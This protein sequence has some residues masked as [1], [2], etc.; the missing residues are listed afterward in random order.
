[1][2]RVRYKPNLR[3]NYSTKQT[4]EWSC[5]NRL[6]KIS[7][8]NMWISQDAPHEVR[9][10]FIWK[11]SW[12][13]KFS[14]RSCS[15]NQPK[16]PY[17]CIFIGGLEYLMTFKAKVPSALG[18]SSSLPR[19][20]AA[21]PPEERRTRTSFPCRFSPDQSDLSHHTPRWRSS[22]GCQRGMKLHVLK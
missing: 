16:F 18:L 12:N 4:S 1:M 21:S 5:L 2:R 17:W 15:N 9:E 11:K 10:H 6:G 7:A 20:T 8:N 14:F 3:V 22:L 19:R 13:L